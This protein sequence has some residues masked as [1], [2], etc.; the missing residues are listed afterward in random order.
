MYLPYSVR[1]VFSSIR[2]SEELMAKF[3]VQKSGPL[4]GEVEISGSKNAVLPIMAATLL[5]E[6]QC[7]IMDVPKLRD[8]DVMNQILMRIGAQVQD[9]LEQENK[10]TVA[11]PEIAATEPPYGLVSK[12]RASFVIMGNIMYREFMERIQLPGGFEIGA[13]NI[14]IKILFCFFK[15]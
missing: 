6:E 12:M 10:L 4:M 8:V 5:C 15:A 13:R 3:I 9:E 11:T 7:V 1:Q 14:Y 2:N